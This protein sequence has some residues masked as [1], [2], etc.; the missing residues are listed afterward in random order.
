MGMRRSDLA[1]EAREIWAAEEGGEPAGVTLEKRQRDGFPAEVVRVTTQAGARAIGKSMGTYVTVDLSDLLRRAPDALERGARA[2]AGELAPLLPPEGGTVLVV[3]LGNRAITP[4]AVGP[5]CL[6]HVLV[7]RHL[8]EELPQHFGMLRPVSALAAGVLGDTGV[9]SGELA[10]AVVER[11]RPACVI[12][13]DAL[14]SRS[15][16][17]LCRTVQLSDAGIA[18]GSG[19]GNHRR[20]LDRETL[21]VP[22]IAL[23]VPTV[24]DGATLA[25]DLLE[26][27]PV[28]P[29]VLGERGRDLF[30]TPR[31]IDVRVAD[32]AR[33]VGY[34]INL[35]LQ[36]GL[37]WGDMETLLS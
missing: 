7:T 25:L 28:P 19:V 5:L 26:G 29:G 37:S 17:R 12:A 35:A 34:A 8:V 22:V 31:E 11:L 14:A 30:V 27:A 1:V 23:G 15:L 18:P 21:G 3:G 16:E 9:E 32:A 2:I 13:V 4:D 24:V 6:R 20:A 36:P 33:L 10:A